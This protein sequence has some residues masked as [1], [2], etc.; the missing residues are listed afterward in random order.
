MCIICKQIV[1]H[2]LG[3]SE[4]KNQSRTRAKHRSGGIVCIYITVKYKREKPDS[5]TKTLKRKER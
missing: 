5:V 1:L 4:Q 2:N 3:E